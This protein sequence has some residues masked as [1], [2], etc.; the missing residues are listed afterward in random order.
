MI[1][2]EQAG[3]Q[4]YVDRVT[5]STIE[6]ADLAQPPVAAIFLSGPRG[7][8]I[9]SHRPAA[10]SNFVP[11]AAAS[12]PIDVRG[13]AEALRCQRAKFQQFSR[14]RHAVSA[15]NTEHLLVLCGLPR[16]S[17]EVAKLRS[18]SNR[19]PMPDPPLHRGD[20]HVRNVFVTDPAQICCHLG[21]H[22]CL[23]PAVRAFGDAERQPSQSNYAARRFID[24]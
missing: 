18:A 10:A 7:M 11:E 13:L 15:A 5:R 8:L 12:T 24:G 1:I 22:R 3:G 9:A 4:P 6:T 20:D 21:G 14:Y 23:R 16:D 17:A 2:S 19:R